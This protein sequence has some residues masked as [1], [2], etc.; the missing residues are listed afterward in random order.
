MS[1]PVQTKT[2]L[3]KLTIDGK[4]VEVPKGTLLI[5]AA[6]KSG[7][8]IPYFCY[9]GKL[10]SDGN[11]RMCLVMIEKMPKLQVSCSVS[12]SEGMVVHTENEVVSTARKGV[13]DFILAN[14]PLDCP[15]CDEGGRC[16]LQNYS[17]KYTAYGEF[18]EQKRVFEKDYFSPLIE[19]EMNR[20]VQCMRCVRYCDEVIDAK[21]LASVNRG[22]EVAIEHYAGKQLDCEFCG[23]CV[24]I[25]PVG[26]ILN[27]V[28]LYEF[29]PWMLKRTETTCAYCADGCSL[30]LETRQETKKIVE[31]TSFWGNEPRELWENTRNQGDLCAKGYFGYSFVNSPERLTKPLIRKEGQLVETSWEEA[32]DF[33]ADGLKR[34]RDRDGGKAIAGLASARC[35]NENLFVFQKFLR[36]GLGSPNIDSTP[37][38]G[39]ANAA[40][41]L[42][43][44]TGT[45]RWLPSYEDISKA[46]LI[47]VIGADLTH[48]NPIAALK[49]K[50]AA[51]RGAKLIVA[52]PLRKRISTI[53]NIVNLATR[54]LAHHPG[55]ERVVA[56]LMVKA[57]IGSGGVSKEFQQSP[58]F[59]ELK[60]STDSLNEKTM[61]AD[62]G[63]EYSEIEKAAEE[64]S[65]ASRVVI[66][67]GEAVLRSPDGYETLRV[68]GDLAAG[69]GCLTAEGCGIAPLYKENNELGAWEMGVLPDRL[70]GGKPV[71]GEKGL[72]LTGMLQGARDG[73]IKGLYFMGENPVG[74]LPASAN[75]AEAVKAAEFSVCQDLFLT[76]TAGL[77]DVVFPAASFAEQD[78]TFTNQEGF[79]QPVRR[80]FD[81]IQGANT[82]WQIISEL[83]LAM[84]L[85][86]DYDDEAGIGEEIQS[87]WAGWR[88]R[89]G[90]DS[91]KAS[92][93][94]YLSGGVGK[95]YQFSNGK[96]K[97]PGKGEVE[98]IVGPSLFHSGK[99]SLQSPGLLLTEG[100]GALFLS[101]EDA[102][103]IGVEEGKNVKILSA[104]GAAEVSVRIDARFP[105]GVAFFPESFSAP[106]VRDLLEVEVTGSEQVPVFR[107]KIV[108]VEKV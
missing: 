48:T 92:L 99:M 57:L 86:F 103:R 3:V 108:S 20:C 35:T 87:K 59:K 67:V 44:L 77:C 37:R 82:D 26:A 39:M 53:S 105:E 88:S 14:H 61:A 63:L 78:G 9:H 81:P 70:P 10:K 80:A 27:R 98:L 25:C 24:Q 60:Q 46:E 4:N 97:R 68:L 90:R 36:E 51:K 73:G 76:E 62:A 11:C 13:L 52:T 54:R 64:W 1:D 95:R 56:A 17:Q 22:S 79:V 15:I 94:A 71:E 83:A 85:S 31:V 107:S 19:K 34:I 66:L 69:S 6:R 16:P 84:G 29:R 18:G 93:S 58:V 65:K 12:V 42:S 5:E 74:T 7:I 32:I 101:P 33:A 43:E 102:G 91:A 72:T 104:G 49:V 2:D 23:G 55:A 45:A 38:Y 89:P 50:G 8:E 28:A 21:A 100:K 96:I 30:R 75:A 106:A 40:V 47:F 41:A